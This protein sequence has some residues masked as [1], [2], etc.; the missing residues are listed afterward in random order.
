MKIKYMIHRYNLEVIVGLRIAGAN[1]L[2]MVVKYMH[3]ENS[4]AM[5]CLSARRAYRFKPRAQP[6][7]AGFFPYVF[8]GGQ[9]RH[10][11]F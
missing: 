2:P 11:F 5:I 9:A 8:W 7:P 6:P 10:V 4:F 1:C 3:E